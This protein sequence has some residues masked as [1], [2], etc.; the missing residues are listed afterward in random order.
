MDENKF[1]PIESHIRTFKEEREEHAKVW[2]KQ[3][4]L[5]ASAVENSPDE[6]LKPN[7]FAAVF[8]TS[9]T[10]EEIFATLDFSTVELPDMSGYSTRPVLWACVNILMGI[11]LVA[12]DEKYKMARS[13]L[14]FK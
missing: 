14:E 1:E 7:I 8:C 3:G 13:T 10:A 12:G 5:L 11:T 9:M 4:A 2:A 6:K